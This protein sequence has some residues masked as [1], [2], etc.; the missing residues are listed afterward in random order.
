MNPGQEKHQVFGDYAA[1]LH[2][3]LPQAK[4][5]LFFDR[6]A[7]LFWYDSPPD[8]S[9]LEGEFQDTLDRIL[10][11]QELPDEAA[12]IPLG[13]QVAYLI[14]LSSDA[15]KPL[16]VLTALVERDVGG[17][18]HKF[19]ADLLQPALRSLQREL[20]LR[21]HLLDAH[22]R[23][24]DHSH[25]HQFLQTL[26]EHARHVGTTQD[27]VQGILE[28]CITQLRL[29]GICLYAPAYELNLSAGGVPV[30]PRQ[31]ELLLESLEDEAAAAPG[32]AAAALRNRPAPDPQLRLRSWPIFEGGQRLAGVLIMSCSEDLPAIPQR[33]I[34]LA[35]FVVSTVEH[36]LDK[37]Y[38]AVTG[39]MKWSEFETGLEQACADQAEDCCLIYLDIDQ[40]HLANDTFGRAIGDRVL[41]SLA[42]LMRDLFAGH[43]MTRVTSDSYAVMLRGLS[44]DQTAGLARELCARA[45]Q[46]EHVE[47]EQSYRLSLSIGV[48]PLIIETDA[49][50]SVLV[51]AQIACQAAKDRGR[52]RVE[53]Y[54]SADQS[55]V[56]RFDDLKFVG[57]IRSAIEAGRLVLF[58]QP[59]ERI[60]GSTDAAYHELLVRMLDSAGEPMQPSEFMGAAERYRLMQDLDRWVVRKAIETLVEQP[61]D[62][63]GRPLRFAVNLSGQSI[64]SADFLSFVQDELRRSGLAGAKLCFEITETVAVSNLDNAQ[65][66]MREMQ[67]LGCRFSLD[68]FGTGHSSFAYLKLFPIDTLKIDGS[69][70]RDIRSNVVSRSMVTAIAEIAKVM[71]IETV[72]EYVLDGDILASVRELGV[73]WAQ[74]YF[75]G[76]PV[77]LR[78][79]VG[80]S[81]LIDKADLA[82]VDPTLIASLPA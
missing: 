36:L 9:Q 76:E 24:N 44:L 28:H 20:S 31:A 68:D 35:A 71:E 42:R 52:A 25:E 72:A 78:Q 40:L 27:I 15:G 18:P 82:D 14:R 47:N 23:L 32:S 64:G 4:N 48:A 5:F 7:D 57:S 45:S 1:F 30:D 34:G 22:R 55:I 2:A 56:R 41:R 12:R 61:N 63:E 70:V 62:A 33:S 16:G 79:L 11:N 54:E 69:F 21:V 77:R 49:A 75:L 73:D 67:A 53:V 8:T 81:T 58:A 6:H 10:T 3:L 74:G 17:M 50:G 29:G 65:T 37:G 59:I 38:D 19:C 66:F 46:F 13:E 26:G 51:P 60:N 80:N 43:A 39:L